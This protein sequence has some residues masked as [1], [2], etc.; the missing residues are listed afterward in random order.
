MKSLEA[1]EFRALCLKLIDEASVSGDTLML[2]KSGEPVARL[3]RPKGAPKLL[4]GAHKGQI[5][6]LGDIVSPIDEDW[7]SERK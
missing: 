1:S 2:L 5:E 3:S 6:I 7:D 4:F